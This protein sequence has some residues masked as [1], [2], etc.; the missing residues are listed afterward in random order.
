MIA[1]V[2]ARFNK[3]KGKE[4]FFLTGTDEHGQ[5]IAQAAEKAGKEPKEFIDSLI[6]SY[7]DIWQKYNIDYSCF[8]RTTDIKHVQAVQK[9]LQQLI[10]KGDIYK[11]T[12]EGWYC[13]PCETFLTEKEAQQLKE[14]ETV[15]RCLLCNR[16]T[17]FISEE[18]YFFRL[19]AYQD[20]LLA[21]YKNNPDFITPKERLNEVIRFVESGLRD[22]SIS[23]TTVTWGIPFLNDPKHVAYVWADALNNYIT[24]I[25][26][27][28]KEHEDNFHKWWPADVHVLGKDILRFHAIYW[29]AFLMASDLPLPKKLLVHGWIKV[30]EQK[31]SKSLGNVVDPDVLYH[32]FGTDPVRYYLMR[33]I[34]VTQDSSFYFKKLESAVSSDLANDLGNLLNRSVT[35]ATRNDLFELTARRVWSDEAIT[36]RDDAY[37]MLQAYTEYMDE[38]LFHM[39]LAEIWKFINHVNAYFHEH[40]PWKLAK[41]NKNAFEEVI[42]ATCHSLYMIAHLLWPIMPEKME[43]L[44]RSLGAA[45]EPRVGKDIIYSFKSDPWSRSFTLLALSPLFKKPEPIKLEETQKQTKESYQA[46][47]ETITINDV[48]KVQLVVGTIEQCQE[49]PKSDKLY[50]FQVNFGPLGTRQILAGI[51][52]YFMPDELI[53]KQGIF[54]FNLQPRKMLGLES[55]GMMLLA[56]DAGGKLQM[57]T[58]ARPVLNGTRLQ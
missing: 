14:D 39:A 58:I 30:D 51:R 4:V 42:A 26:Y 23:R 8:I 27:G 52:K 24:A 55:Q 29:P 25:G 28:C 43:Q 45:L 2:I 57:A 46:K 44:C 18:S 13:T 56:P 48:A 41:E 54:I 49:V 34:A 7:K 47:E 38:Y 21:F 17:Y 53:G 32:H 9:W 35:L 1:D 19:S 22:L 33:Y 20:K 16:L 15:P 3:L 50:K 6:P 12:Y 37:N 36:L 11:S 5:K 10:D 40:E 31:M